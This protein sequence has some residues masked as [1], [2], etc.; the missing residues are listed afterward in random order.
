MFQN[1]C[2]HPPS[3]FRYFSIVHIYTRTM[4][5]KRSNLP[6]EDRTAK[7]PRNGALHSVSLSKIE[8]V[9]DTIR[10]FQLE[11]K[12]K[13]R[14]I[15]VRFLMYFPSYIQYNLFSVLSSPPKMCYDRHRPCFFLEKYS[16]RRI[17]YIILTILVFSPIST[18]IKLSSLSIKSA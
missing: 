18:S 15:K 8:R 7:E 5:T 9:N 1:F 13:E 16:P 17:T 4:A 2:S 3:R 10:L 11:I 14:G 12:D 6:H